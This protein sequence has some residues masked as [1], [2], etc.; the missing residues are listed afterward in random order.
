MVI[1]PRQLNPC[2]KCNDLLEFAKSNREHTHMKEIGE[3]IHY[4]RKIETGIATTTSRFY[5]CPECGQLWQEVEQSGAGG[6][7]RYLRFIEILR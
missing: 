6:L 5:Q 1:E 3:P 7:T 2:R 4:A